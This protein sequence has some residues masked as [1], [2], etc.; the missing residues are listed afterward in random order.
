MDDPTP[1]S[2]SQPQPEPSR[3]DEFQTRFNQAMEPLMH[4]MQHQMLRIEAR[5]N[6]LESELQ[7]LHLR[8]NS[9]DQRLEKLE[10]AGGQA[11]ERTAT[12]E[13]VMTELRSSRAEGR[14]EVEV[15]KQRLAGVTRVEPGANG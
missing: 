2:P 15:L 5:L 6:G 8:L 14:A 4:A 10:A 7:L 13:A 12:M 11:Q 3:P 9:V 1:A